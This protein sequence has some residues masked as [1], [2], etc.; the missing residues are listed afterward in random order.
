MAH[1]RATW[2]PKTDMPKTNNPEQYDFIPKEIERERRRSICYTYKVIYDRIKGAKEPSELNDLR[3][4]SYNLS[5]V[6]KEHRDAFIELSVWAGLLSDTPNMGAKCE[7]KV[8]T[9]EQFNKVVLYEGDK[10]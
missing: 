7:T 1:Q 8:E 9:P 3:W 10:I 6:I 5:V 2:H 4:L